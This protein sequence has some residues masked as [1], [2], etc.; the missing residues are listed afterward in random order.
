MDVVALDGEVDDAESRRVATRGTQNG[1][2]H[3][4]KDMLAAQRREARA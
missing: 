4:G 1:E 3:R 2:S